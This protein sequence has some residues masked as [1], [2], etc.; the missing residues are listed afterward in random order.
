M[1]VQRKKQSK[2]STAGYGVNESHTLEARLELL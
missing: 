1:G 2:Q